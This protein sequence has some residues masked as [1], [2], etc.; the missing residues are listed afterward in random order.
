MCCSLGT[1]A[2]RLDALEHRWMA[3]G[4]EDVQPVRREVCEIVLGEL[5]E[6]RDERLGVLVGLQRVGVGLELVG[7]RA[8]RQHDLHERV[9][10]REEELEEDEAEV[11]EVGVD[12]WVEVA[13]VLGV[14]V[15]VVVVVEVAV[16]VIV[17]PV[18]SLSLI[19]I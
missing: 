10:G 9:D 2:K 19:H 4:E 15:P 16:L 13:V 7:A 3:V 18:V 11:V 5:L 14:L 8:H 6:G 12:V 17:G 1:A